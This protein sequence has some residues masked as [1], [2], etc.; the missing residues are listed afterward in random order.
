MHP[1]LLLLGGV[2]LVLVALKIVTFLLVQRWSETLTFRGPVRAVEITLGKGEVIV[3]GGDRRDARVRRRMRHGLRAPKISEHVDEGVL[4]LEVSSGI[5]QYEVDV[6]AGA[7]VLVRG[8][9]VSATVVGMAG[10]V[11]L[12]PGTGSIEGRAL[13]A[14][15]VWATTAAG[16]IRLSFDRAPDV[17]D[18]TTRQGSVDLALPDGPYDVDAGDADVGVRCAAGAKRRVRARSTHGPVHIRHR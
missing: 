12:R 17:V 11:E 3:R 1:L 18:V 16:S 13:S 14:G 7:S 8:S 9:T 10:P 5:V 2:V 6:P 4:R 15:R